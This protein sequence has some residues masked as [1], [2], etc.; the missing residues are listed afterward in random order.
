MA[1]WLALLAV[2]FLTAPASDPNQNEVTMKLLTF[3][4][5]GIN[6]S[7]VALFNLMGVWPLLFLV[8]LGF[9]TTEQR[10]WRWPFLLGS[11]ILGAFA[12]L[13][14]LVLR[15]WGAPKRAPTVKWL[16]ALG[17]RTFAVM[18]LV[19]AGAMCAWFIVGD[20]AAFARLFHT[21]QFAYVMS[22]DF[23]ACTV[24][25]VLLCIEDASVRPAAPGWAWSI[26]SAVGFSVRLVQAPLAR[27]R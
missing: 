25:G 24:A 27:L 16:R 22:F 14:Y 8:M 6:Q 19:G 3:Q 21:N 15:R 5:D 7:F 18:L 13:P 12:L 26:G 10:V 17:S 11:F 20:V 9:D 23:I 2:A 1:T 4:L